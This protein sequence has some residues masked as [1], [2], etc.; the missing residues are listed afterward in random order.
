[1]NKPQ[2]DAPE[3]PLARRDP[4]ALEF[5]SVG[6]SFL[7]REDAVIQVI[8]GRYVVDT[9]AASVADIGLLRVKVGMRSVGVTVLDPAYVVFAVPVSW[10]GDYVIN[11]Q[12]AERDALYMP[13]DLDTVH[14]RGDQRDTIGV[15]LPRDQFTEAVA[16]LR[17]V[18]PEDVTLLDRELWLMPAAGN[19]LRQR[20]AGLVDEACSERRIRAPEEIANDVLTLI[21]DAYLHACPGAAPSSSRL[22][23]PKRIVRAAEEYFVAQAG[24]PIS[25]AGLCAAAGV[26][27]SSLYLA[28]HQI[29]GEPPLEYL[30]KRQLTQAR[31]LLLRADPERGVVKR[32]ALDVGLT[33]FGR[34]SVEYRRL[35]G[36]SPSATLRNQ[37]SRPA[38]DR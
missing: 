28:F 5:A 21:I 16:A 24:A 20:L 31:S 6:P 1:M 30:R 17:G 25:L 37:A 8:G 23:R 34:F 12:V 36:E 32:T 27:K 7:A 9:T 2:D 13:G 33:E 15:G 18:G 11:G 35:F 4:G 10:T 26:S 3:P 19:I 38:F 29:C 22:R 14:I